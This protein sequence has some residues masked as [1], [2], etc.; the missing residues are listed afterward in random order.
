[1]LCIDAGNSRV[2]LALWTDG[3]WRHR[4]AI[5]HDEL[6]G[7]LETSRSILT[8]VARVVACN[9][10]GDSVRQAIDRVA[11]ELGCRV[12]WL[13]ATASCAGVSNGYRQPEQLGADRWAALIA[14]RGLQIV[15]S[16]ATGRPLLIM[17][18]GTATT[19]DGLDRGG[20]FRG[21]VILPGLALMQQSLARRT[22]QLPEANGSFAAW[23]TQ[24]DD[25]IVS[26]S[27]QATLGA[28]ERMR[29]NWR[30]GVGN[31]VAG[32]VAGGA[33]AA[34]GDALGDSVIWQPDLV[35]DGLQRFA[36]NADHE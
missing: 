1:M 33:A 34:L 23:P 3:S 10:A 17:M 9:V 19:I 15:D 20:Q 29:R 7:W 30:E 22:A 25:A 35:L 26:G 36:T 24:T 21:G 8:N 28:F 13:S 27:L 6:D 31:E 12:E 14:G 11:A 2:K 5:A 18:M 16:R 4:A 32:V